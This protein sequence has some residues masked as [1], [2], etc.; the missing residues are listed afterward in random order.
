[1]E[2]KNWVF[3]CSG[4]FILIY[5]IRI[6]GVSDSR[7]WAKQERMGKGSEKKKVTMRQNYLPVREYMELLR[8]RKCSFYRFTTIPPPELLQFV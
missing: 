7:E 2:K 6:L 4:T 1:M 3:K 5:F 8:T